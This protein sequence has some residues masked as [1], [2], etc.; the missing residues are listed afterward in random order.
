MVARAR[1]GDD[2]GVRSEIETSWKG[3]RANERYYGILGD[4]MGL[5]CFWLGK[6]VRVGVLR[7]RPGEGKF[8]VVGSGLMF[9]G[10]RCAYPMA[11]DLSEG[12]CE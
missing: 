10:V 7:P 8:A 4:G 2:R 6:A 1:L 12:C 11:A 9:G 3:R 5:G